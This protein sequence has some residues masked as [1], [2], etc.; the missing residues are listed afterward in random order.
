M[1][2]K[3][4]L[5]VQGEQTQGGGSGRFGSTWAGAHWHLSAGTHHCPR[6]CGLNVRQALFMDEGE[7][8]AAGISEEHQ[9]PAR[10]P[11]RR[12][13]AEQGRLPRH[14]PPPA[15]PA[16]L[17]CPRWVRRACGPRQPTSRASGVRKTS[18]IHTEQ[19]R[20]QILLSTD[21]MP[22]VGKWKPTAVFLPRKSQGQGS[23][24]GYS[25]QGRRVGQDGACTLL[26]VSRH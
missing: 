18:F 8:A 4:H 7:R 12:G 26:S 2:G 3:S 15:R 17:S 22:G 24:V 5:R 21:C 20:T 19:T 6:R 10:T 1:G 25:P 16:H 14:L 11:L 9:V 13:S 23:L